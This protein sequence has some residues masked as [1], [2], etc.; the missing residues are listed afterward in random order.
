MPGRLDVVDVGAAIFLPAL[1]VFWLSFHES[2]YGLDPIF[3]GLR[4]YRVVL[5]DPYFWNALRNTVIVATVIGLLA[6]LIPINFLAEMTSIGTLVAFVVVS[7]GVMVLRQRQPDLPR[8]FK[9]PLYPVIPVLA[10]LGSLWII[11]DL[12]AVT[13]YV[14]LIWVSIAMVWYF[15]Y[16][17]R[18]SHLGRHEHVGLTKD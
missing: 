14:F 8:G 6:G 16:G 7:I 3:V 2:S 1:Y 5:A 12:R 9:V 10:I 17:I 11:S 13:I 4:N 18:H 15:V